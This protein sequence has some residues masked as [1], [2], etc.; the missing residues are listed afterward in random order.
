MAVRSDDVEMVLKLKHLTV[1]SLPAQPLSIKVQLVRHRFMCSQIP[2]SAEAGPIRL[3][4]RRDQM[5]ADVQFF[6]LAMSDEDFTKEIRFRLQNETDFFQDVGGVTREVYTVAAKQLFAESEGLFERILDGADG[7]Y[8]RISNRYNSDQIDQATVD[9]YNFAGKLLGKVLMDGYTV[10]VPLASV[11]YRQLQKKACGMDELK[12]MDFQMHGSLVWMLHND[13]NELEETFAIAEAGPLG[14][15]VERELCKEGKQLA[16]TE[17]NKSRYVEMRAHWE[18]EGRIEIQLKAFQQGVWSVIPSFVALTQCMSAKD[19]R[20]LWCGH[21]EI[22]V[23]EW[24]ES[25]AYAPPCTAQDEVVQWFWTSVRGM[26]DEQR[27]SLLYFVTGSSCVPVEGFAGLSSTYGKIYPF[28]ISTIPMT[29][30]SGWCL[31]RAHTC[32][33]RL[34]LPAYTSQ[35]MLADNLLKVLEPDAMGFGMDE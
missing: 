24:F 15:V 20:Q 27:S 10:P 3:E 14:K 8:L 35:E 1:E 25:T 5:A 22:D 6:F 13:V 2:A 16:V 7:G 28:S 30:T 11:L 26:T 29:S 17:M 31:P 18:L 4:L 9:K 21:T 32:F 34:D 33:N 12:K 23:Q 19:L